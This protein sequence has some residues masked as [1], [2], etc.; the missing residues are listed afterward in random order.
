MSNQ[1]L[2]PLSVPNIAGNEWKYVKDCL[3]TGWISS[4]GSYVTQFEQMVAQFAGAKYGVATVN[5]TSALH[6]SL[7][8]S[9]VKPDDYVI[10]PNL[11]FVASANS[12]KYI[13]AEPILIDADPDY[14]QMDLDLLEEF[15]ENETDEKNGE[16]IYIQDG[17]RIAAIMPVHI[18]GN[19]CD[20]DRFAS[21]IK[22]YPLPVVE[23][24][25]EALGTS[26]KGKHA[27]TFSPLG[28]FSFNGNKIISTG[29][30]GVIVS[31]NEELAKK[32]K[33]ITN[34]AKASADEYYH[35]EVGYNYRLVNILAAVGVAQMELL[36]SFIKRKK[37]A[38][39]FYKK[40]LAGVADIRFQKESPDVETNGWLFT[41]QTKHQQQLLDHLNSNKILSRRFWMP[42]NK[43]PMYK[44]CP[45]IQK[46]DNADYIYNT[47]L[48]I[49]CSTSITDEQL[50][51]VAKEVKLALS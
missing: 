29:G 10:L 9:G 4:V 34:T 38:V 8:L 23:D 31:D 40:E 48:S 16:L 27:G 12:I 6:I 46:K 47:C 15:L 30:G 44:D 42:M 35:D 1:Q 22:K 18:L 25:T 7:L 45:Y 51:I 14:W 5:G 49:P 41:I 19:M 37:E 28:C 3:D 24:A 32:A 50:E 11:T 13:G 33:H 43:L 39:A 26:Y 21:I 20:M 2:I 36:P 17:R